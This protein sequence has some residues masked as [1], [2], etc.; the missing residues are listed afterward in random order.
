MHSHIVNAAGTTV[1]N[2]GIVSA[3][4][5]QCR[6]Y[7][8]T[9]RA[10]VFKCL[11]SQGWQQKIIYQPANRFWTFQGIESAIFLVLAAAVIP[12]AFIAIRRDA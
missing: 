6:Q 11:G 5:A 8:G 9:T 7:I 10:Q 12:A 3:I 4:P 1:P 2:Q